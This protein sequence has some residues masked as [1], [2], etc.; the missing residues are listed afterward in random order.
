MTFVIL[1]SPDYRCLVAGLK[2]NGAHPCPR[3][4]IIKADIGMVGSQSDMAFRA[5]VEEQRCYCSLVYDAI[6]TARRF[7]YDERKSVSTKIVDDILDRWSLTPIPVHILFA[8]YSFA[9]CPF[10]MHSGND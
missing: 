4:L 3:C 6:A 1:V 10:R 2:N 5:R 8:L 9:D 7:I